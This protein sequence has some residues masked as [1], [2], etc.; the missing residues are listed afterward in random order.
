MT[1]EVENYT[2]IDDDETKYMVTPWG[3]L[4]SVLSDYGIE[5]GHVAGRVGAHIVDDFMDA[6]TRAGYVAK[7]DEEVVDA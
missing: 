1:E 4:Y 6:M 3:C 2:D 5:V 7:K